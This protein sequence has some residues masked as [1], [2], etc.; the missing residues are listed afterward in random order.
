MPHWSPPEQG[1]RAAEASGDG[2]PIAAAYEAGSTPTA[3]RRGRA[4]AGLLSGLG[5]DEAQLQRP[6]DELSGGW[7]M[8]LNLACVLMAPAR[9]AAAR[10]ADQ[11]PRPRRRALA[12]APAAAAC[13][14]SR[15]SSPMTATSSTGSPIAC[16]VIE[17]RPA[18]PLSAAAI[19]PARQLRA[20]HAAQRERASKAQQQRRR[21]PDGLRRAL[22]G[23]GDQGAPGA[24][25]AEGAREDA[26]A[27][28]GA[29]RAPASTSISRP[30]ARPRPADRAPR[31]AS[32]ATG[33]RRRSS[34]VPS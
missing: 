8:R 28:T 9:P 21:P 13:R 20:E 25:P 16:L 27:G 23:Q 3:R 4:P 17:D 7:K 10:R 1:G 6:V 30:A 32:A 29:G 15:S 18:H 22:P 26:G 14:R 24:E 11:P 2:L 12:R 5:F 34:R 33:R 19:A 31:P